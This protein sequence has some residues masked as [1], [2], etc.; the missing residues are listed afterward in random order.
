M[1]S[2]NATPF[3]DQITPALGVAVNDCRP[4]AGIVSAAGFTAKAAAATTFTVV[5]PVFDPEV[6]VIVTLPGEVGATKSPVPSMVPA[7]AVHVAPVLTPFRNAAKW[8][9]WLTP[10]LEEPGT[11]TRS[12]VRGGLPP[13][14]PLLQA[15]RVNIPSN[16]IVSNAT[17]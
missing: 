14:P 8:A 7:L 3:T 4:P 5:V 1:Q 15:E 10:T 12:F 16:A 6:A 9:V 13:P 11:T 2:P 17:K